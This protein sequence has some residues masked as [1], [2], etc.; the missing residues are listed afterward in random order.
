ME[1]GSGSENLADSESLPKL[2]LRCSRLQEPQS[3]GGGLDVGTEKLWEGQWPSLLKDWANSSIKSCDSPLASDSSSSLSTKDSSL[4][5]W[6]E[7]SYNAAKHV[8][9]SPELLSSRFSGF[10]LFNSGKNN[11]EWEC[12]DSFY[13]ELSISKDDKQAGYSLH[14]ND[15][16]CRLVQSACLGNIDESRPPELRCDT[17]DFHK[18]VVTEHLDGGWVSDTS[19]SARS[20]ASLSSQDLQGSNLYTKDDDLGGDRW[21]GEHQWPVLTSL[22]RKHPV[23]AD[24]G[25]V[26]P[27]QPQIPSTADL[28][29]ND[30]GSK[31]NHNI[32]EMCNGVSYANSFKDT[33]SNAEDKSSYAGPHQQPNTGCLKECHKGHV[34]Q[35]EGVSVMAEIVARHLQS[36]HKGSLPTPPNTVVPNFLQSGDAREP[37]SHKKASYSAAVKERFA[38]STMHG[39]LR[40]AEQGSSPCY[41]FFLDDSDEVLFARASRQERKSNKENCEWTYSF[42]S[43]KDNGKAKG[44]WKSWQKK[45]N[46]ASDLVA[47]MRVSGLGHLKAKSS[48]DGRTKGARF[49][50]YDGGG[51]HRGESQRAGTKSKM[52]GQPLTPVFENASSSQAGLI[53]E[54]T[55]HCCT[56]PDGRTAWHT[57]GSKKRSNSPETG[58]EESE[59]QEFVKARLNPIHSQQAEL[60]AIVISTSVKEK[61]IKK[62][63]ESHVAQK[64]AAGWGINFLEKGTQSG[65]G[66]SLMDKSF[67]NP[68]NVEEMAL[69]R[70]LGRQGPPDCS[71]GDLATYRNAQVKPNN[72][73]DKNPG[74]PCPDCAQKL[75]SKMNTRKNRLK[76]DVTV[77]LPAGDHGLPDID[78]D[79]TSG[80]CALYGPTPLLERWMS[81]GDCECGGWDMGCGM[82]VYKAETISLS[83][84]TSNIALTRNDRLNWLSPG[85]PFKLF[86]QGYMCKKVLVLEMVEAGLFSLS[87]QA[88][89]SPLQAF[90]IAVALFHQQMIEK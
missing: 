24:V 4:F 37:F 84:R 58:K 23:Q 21:C 15:K 73:K 79:N 87:F 62:K 2:F 74:N 72:E 53:K 11:L 81:G 70:A 40:S 38:S 83:R 31:Q 16:P 52:R 89:V 51:E 44:A 29:G 61:K 18:G 6:S 67:S 46:L 65:W 75:P 30:M 36:T 77:I 22:S 34:A 47:S 19:N 55:K 45:E 8:L 88:R 60:A 25:L 86:T 66:L 35:G 26:K 68:K 63:K 71:T 54:G 90:A 7:N 59:I 56:H 48:Q 12:R 5:S 82:S 1:C 85:S 14:D 33:A 78:E 41:S 28:S 27:V 69:C 64:D 39:Y 42:H 10:S 32:T 13:S 17:D 76:V 9:R 80:V 43:K 20:L 49:V 57:K 50:L 3:E